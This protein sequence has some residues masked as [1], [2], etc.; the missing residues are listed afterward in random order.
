MRRAC[1]Q[2][3]AAVVLGELGV[4]RVEFGVVAVGRLDQR[5]GWS[6]TISRGTP[7]MNS[8]ACTWASIHSAVVWRGVA[9]AKV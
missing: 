5:A 7:A 9:Q 8:S 2:R 3:G 6:G 4:G 1:W